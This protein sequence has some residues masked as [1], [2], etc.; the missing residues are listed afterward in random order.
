MSAVCF[1]VGIINCIEACLIFS[2]TFIRITSHLF[3]ATFLIFAGLS[4]L[5]SAIGNLWEQ[6]IKEL[7]E[8]KSNKIVLTGR[9]Q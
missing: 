2:T 9:S 4:S 8:E 1:T 5:I 3:V 6:R 7:K